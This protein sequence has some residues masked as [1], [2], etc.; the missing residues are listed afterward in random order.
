MFPLAHRVQSGPAEDALVMTARRSF[1]VPVVLGAT[2]TGCRDAS[3]AAAPRFPPVVKAEPMVERDVPISAEW[4][5][6]LRPSFSSFALAVLGLGLAAVRFLSA[7]S[8]RRKTRRV[9]SSTDDRRN[10]RRD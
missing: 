5:G 3:R 7:E 1:V 10:E 2:V 4:V 8:P 9:V 6:T